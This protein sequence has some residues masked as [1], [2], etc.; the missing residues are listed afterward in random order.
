MKSISDCFSNQPAV[1]LSARCRS[2]PVVRCHSFLLEINAVPLVPVSRARARVGVRY[3]SMRNDA[4]PN[5][6]GEKNASPSVTSLNNNE[7]EWH[8]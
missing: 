7:K 4:F 2:V 6:R 1:P 5:A 3:Y 8:H